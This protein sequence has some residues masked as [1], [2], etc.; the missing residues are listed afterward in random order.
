MPSKRVYNPISVCYDEWDKNKV[1]II[2]DE[3]SEKPVLKYDG[4]QPVGIS[5]ATKNRKQHIW[6]CYGIKKNR[7]YVIERGKGKFV[8]EWNGGWDCS[9]K[10]RD[11]GT[12]TDED[13]DDGAIVCHILDDI[14]NKLEQYYNRKK[15]NKEIEDY[16][17]IPIYQFSKVDPDEVEENNDKKK[18]KKKKDDDDDE[19]ENSKKKSK[20]KAKVVDMNK[21]MY[22]G[23]DCAYS[24]KSGKKKKKDGTIPFDARKLT[25][26]A[27]KKTKTGIEETSPEELLLEQDEFRQFNSIPVFNMYI[28]QGPSLDK[29]RI[30]LRLNEIIYSSIRYKKE[31]LLKNFDTNKIAEMPDDDDTETKR[32]TK[33]T[34]PKFDIPPDEDNNDEEKTEELKEDS[35]IYS[36]GDEEKPKRKSKEK[37]KKKK[38]KV[39]SD[40]DE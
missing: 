18:K 23:V 31:S 21:P 37:T 19:E 6:I 22:I 17:M 20:K 10:M 30:K 13:M 32:D 35:D 34:K 16:K 39:D 12:Y 7:K 33:Q 14:Q 15:N 29:I 26:V 11:T 27:Y 8:D 38:K 4:H 28:A 9:F 25:V 36:S 3:E 24:I 5:F 2:E 40:E 1:E